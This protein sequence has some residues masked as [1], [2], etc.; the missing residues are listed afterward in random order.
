MGTDSTFWE[1]DVVEIGCAPPP[2]GS[3][4][5]H[6][7]P[8][9]PTPQERREVMAKWFASRKILAVGGQADRHI[10]QSIFDNLGVS[11]DNFS[12]ISS[13]YNKKAS[14]VGS[15]IKGL[16]AGSSIV[17]CI[18]GKV[19]HSTS[20]S[21]EVACRKGSI[22]YNYVEFASGLQDLLEEIFETQSQLESLNP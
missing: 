4:A 17:V 8:G 7:R 13:E 19:G 15:V 10:K 14:N 12:W 22:A 18:T 5:L 3:I 2:P 11:P 21:V 6:F 20:R 16:Q 9:L 1:S